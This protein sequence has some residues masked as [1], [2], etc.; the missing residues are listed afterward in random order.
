MELK[1][2]FGLP[3]HPLVIHAVVVLLPLAALGL[4]VVAAIPRARRHYAP[5]VLAGALVA[6]LS[7]LVATG[8]GEQ[9]EERVDDSRAA[10][11]STRNEASA[12]SPGRSPWWSW[13]APW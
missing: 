2:L 13:P 12:F 9:L 1:T 8:S 6:M 4:V 5:V 7:V 10:W 11:S 3:A